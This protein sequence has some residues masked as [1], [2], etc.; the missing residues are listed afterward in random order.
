MT[1]PSV[2]FSPFDE[3]VKLLGKTLMLHPHYLTIRTFDSQGYL[4]ELSYAR[5]K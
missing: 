4:Q 1:K 5:N 3:I 2:S